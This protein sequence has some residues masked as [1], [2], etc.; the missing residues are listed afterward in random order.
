MAQFW[1]PCQDIPLSLGNKATQQQHSNTHAAILKAE[2]P[3]SAGKIQKP[4]L[5][6]V[7]FESI[8]DYFSTMRRP[9]LKALKSC[10]L[11]EGFC[12]NGAFGKIQG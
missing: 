6:Q 7:L 10:V 2:A 5:C 12:M 4:K 3:P 8:L 11:G 1:E 9:R